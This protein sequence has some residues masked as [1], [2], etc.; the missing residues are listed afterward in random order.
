ME[1]LKGIT[2]VSNLQT[3]NC[4]RLL[5]GYPAFMAP[6]RYDHPGF[7]A[8]IV[9]LFTISLQYLAYVAS[10]RSD[11]YGFVTKIVKLF[12]IF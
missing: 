10:L 8:K 4:Y 2:S 5:Y 7:V 3:T 11:H 12:T 6:L 1:K 9:K